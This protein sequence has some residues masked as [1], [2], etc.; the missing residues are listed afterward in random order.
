MHIRKMMSFLTNFMWD[1]CP[2][3]LP[4][5]YGSKIMA[6]GVGTLHYQKYML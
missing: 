2:N 6:C 1:I 3:S 4:T 5:P